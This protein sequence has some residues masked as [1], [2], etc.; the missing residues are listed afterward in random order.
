MPERIKKIKQWLE[1]DLQASISSF[2]TASSDASFR[3]YFR[4]K[5][6]G[7]GEKEL[8][9]SYIVMDAPPEKENIEPFIKIA[10]YFEQVGLHVPHIFEINFI[11]G[12]LLLSDLGKTAYLDMLNQES[13]GQLYDDAFNALIKLQSVNI[14]SLDGQLE[15]PMYS[16]ELLKMEMQLLEDWFIKVHLQYPLSNSELDILHATIERLL[17]EVLC[18]PQVIVHRDYHSRNLMIVDENNPG[19]IDFQ[20]AV[21]G[22]CS[23]DLVSLLNDSYIAW[24]ESQV[25]QWVASFHQKLLVEGIIAEKDFSIFQHWFTTMAMQRQIKVVGIFCRLYHR[26]GKENYLN[27]IP[28]TMAY[29]LRNSAKYPEYQPFHKLMLKLNKVLESR[30]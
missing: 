11:D 8:Q 16:K 13:V 6:S 23:Y 18:Q 27:D 1:T 21:V 12:F 19:I 22:P 7:W 30:P 28:Q 10:R 25:E 15:L 17:D 9:P 5:F 2:E 24:P 29:L 26:D 20:D 14:K 4:V 3:R